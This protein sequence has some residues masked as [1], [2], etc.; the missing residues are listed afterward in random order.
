M[1]A[2]SVLKKYETLE[3]QQGKKDGF[4][5]FKT[6]TVE[7]PSDDGGV[8]KRMPVN[9]PV[10]LRAGLPDPLAGSYSNKA[11]SSEKK[12]SSHYASEAE[13]L[14]QELEELNRQRAAAK[15][16]LGIR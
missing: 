2:S 12:S 16:K 9:I 7:E 11:N 13:R 6:R 5:N 15:A 8:A 4:I 3:C 14:K 1:K 10:H